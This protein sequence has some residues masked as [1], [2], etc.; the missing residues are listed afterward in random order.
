M[1]NKYKTIFAVFA[2]LL[3]LYVFQSG[4]A[5]AAGKSIGSTSYF[6]PPFTTGYQVP[7]YWGHSSSGDSG[8]HNQNTGGSGDTYLNGDGA[9]LGNTAP[10]QANG[11][12]QIIFKDDSTAQADGQT[13]DGSSIADNST[14]GSANNSA[15][16]SGGDSGNGSVLSNLGGF[17]NDIGGYI[18]G[19]VG[20]VVDAVRSAFKQVTFGNQDSGAAPKKSKLI[21]TN[22]V[23][24]IDLTTQYVL[25]SMAFLIAVGSAVGYYLWKKNNKPEN[26][27]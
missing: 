15:S 12:R 2:V 1:K 22:V 16:K 8:R 13:G 5:I 20:Y 9:L 3:L 23:I 26:K 7:D 6:P 21:F 4:K 10:N 14:D 27:A 19:A 25:I 18:N 11:E 17:I 24:P